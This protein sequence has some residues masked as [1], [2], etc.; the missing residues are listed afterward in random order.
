MFLSKSICLVIALLILP[1]DAAFIRVPATG[2]STTTTTTV[3]TYKRTTTDY[4][5]DNTN[6]TIGHLT[7]SLAANKHYMVEYFIRFNSPSAQGV[8][9]VKFNYPASYVASYGGMGGPQGSGSAQ[10]SATPSNGT[11]ITQ[12]IDTQANNFSL[13]TIQLNIETGASGG[14]LDLIIICPSSACTIKTG[15]FARLSEIP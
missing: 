3:F 5:S 8:G 4:T 9:R 12:Y 11:Q 13:A 6:T 14:D 15:S 1:A 7:Y 2:G 10:L